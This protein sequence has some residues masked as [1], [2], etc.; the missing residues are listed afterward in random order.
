MAQKVKDLALSLQCLRLLLRRGVSPQP[1]A[2]YDPRPWN[3]HSLQVHQK[4]KKKKK[5]REER[6]KN[7]NLWPRAWNPRLD[8]DQ[9]TGS[10]RHGSAEMNLTSIYEDAGS[11]PDLAQWVRWQTWLG[12]HIAMAVT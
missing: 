8:K 12:S 2:G 10:S 1:S 7:T 6:K 5:K 4:K 11:I 9:N 3:F